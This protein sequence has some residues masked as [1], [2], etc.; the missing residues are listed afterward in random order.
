MSIVSVDQKRRL[1]SERSRAGFTMIEL[2]L[3]LAIL[4]IL[5]AIVIPKL[6]GRSEQ[7]RVTAAQTE[8]SNLETAL[9]SY[10]VD[11]GS[12]PDS[13]MGL[14]ALMVKPA[15]VDNWRGP[16]M[17]KDIPADPWG[18]PYVYEYPGKHVEGRYD[19]YSWGPDG[20][21]GTDDDITNW[22]TKKPT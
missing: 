11:T 14:Q 20:R 15:N 9:D 10:E 7:A 18:H 17:T 8:I 22:S 19:L 1:R 4:A 3:V 21:A 2:L 12:Y 13:S 6:A 5:A 16:Y